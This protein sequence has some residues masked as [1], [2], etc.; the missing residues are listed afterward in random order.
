MYIFQKKL[1]QMFGRINYFSSSLLCKTDK[2]PGGA[3]PPEM[4][5][6]R[7]GTRPIPSE[8]F[9]L[10]AALR[11]FP[12]EMFTLQPALRTFQSESGINKTAT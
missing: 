9:T 7:T 8:I 11:T 3:I 2:E 4:F 10:H 12:S 5:A 1:L 6:I